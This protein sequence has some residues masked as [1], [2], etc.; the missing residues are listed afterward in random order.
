MKYKIPLICWLKIKI[1]ISP[2]KLLSDGTGCVFSIPYRRKCEKCK[3]FSASKYYKGVF[4][5]IATG[6]KNG[7]QGR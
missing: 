5:N 2:S 1:G 3:Y 7:I 4:E 6:I